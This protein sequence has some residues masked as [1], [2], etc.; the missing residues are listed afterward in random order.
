[1]AASNRDRWVKFA[2]IGLSTTLCLQ[3]LLLLLVL[4]GIS[5][6]AP[7]FI[8]SSADASLEKNG[9][10]LTYDSAR[11]NFRGMVELKGLT[12]RT[13]HADPLTLM[14][15]ETAKLRLHPWRLLSESKV[16]RSIKMEGV[17][18][19][20]GTTGEQALVTEVSFSLRN[21]DKEA[22]ARAFGWLGETRLR[23]SASVDPSMLLSKG[24]KKK[25]PY[26]KRP[27]F[28]AR[29]MQ[30]RR[31]IEKAIH[32]VGKTESSFTIKVSQNEKGQLFSLD[33]NAKDKESGKGLSFKE[34]DAHL[35]L[36]HQDK[37][38]IV[39]GQPTVQLER[40]RLVLDGDA[41]QVGKAKLKI[42]NDNFELKKLRQKLQA[43]LTME[44]IALEGSWDGK[45]ASLYSALEM[46]ELSHEIRAKTRV[47]ANRFFLD[48]ETEYFRLLKSGSLK[49]TGLIH[50]GDLQSHRLESLGLRTP[51]GISLLELN[52]T[53]GPGLSINEAR[54]RAKG[55]MVDFRGVRLD[56]FQASARYFK[57]GTWVVAPLHVK[58][59]DSNATDSFASG[60]Y[61]QNEAN[62]YR[63]LLKGALRGASIN[64]WMVGAWWKN[65]WK[66]FDI[67]DLPPKGDF[68]VTG[69]WGDSKG[70]RTKVQGFVKLRKLDFHKFPIEA[71]TLEVIVDSNRT[72]A[73][74]LDLTLENEGE[75]KANLWWQNEDGN[76]TRMGIEMSLK[77][78]KREKVIRSLSLSSAFSTPTNTDPQKSPSAI[79]EIT[80][81][82]EDESMLDFRLKAKGNLGD[83]SSF[84]GTGA[85]DLKDENLGSVRLFGPLSKVIQE[86]PVPIP[87]GSVRFNRLESTYSWEGSYA[88][89][90]DM[91]ITSSSS[92]IRG[93]GKYWLK[94]NTINFEARMYLL[95]GLGSKIPILGKIAEFLDPL[96]KFIE[97]TLR[98]RLDNPKWGLRVDP[99]LF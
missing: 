8:F 80:V 74:N 65:I 62:D 47:Q 52:A 10:D 50:A 22:V 37:Q 4:T 30:F 41:S 46:V 63:F 82:G 32:Y 9:L 89:F 34:A 76:V 26:F 45:F 2:R 25:L 35:A 23:L 57:G 33:F 84:K 40:A 17:D 81:T 12:V 95:G 11:F 13:T 93:E 94:D 72:L 7:R 61:Q 54:F 38:W 56:R 92:L 75:A 20:F 91:T 67:G 86:N 77:G 53:L 39:V 49:A 83:L 68:D 24:E 28:P 66:D 58:L 44:E 99:E 79:D 55:N 71:G 97:L 36:S 1:M 18:A 14:K 88:T 69:R 6:P 96:S 78:A 51:E 85:I 64:N 42:Q 21:S 5:F 90:K 31:S 98:G 15:I 3:S 27:E 19:L 29:H 48:L 87:S 16:V 43:N 60:S 73:R 59:D 70:D